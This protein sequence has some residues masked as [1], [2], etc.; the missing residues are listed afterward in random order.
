MYYAGAGVSVPAKDGYAR[1]TANKSLRAKIIRLEVL[2]DKHR[3]LKKETYAAVLALGTSKQVLKAFP[4]TAELFGV[5]AAGESAPISSNIID[6]KTKL[7][8]Q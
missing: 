8:K 3:S 7:K 1:L 6:L 4:E 2:R 5:E